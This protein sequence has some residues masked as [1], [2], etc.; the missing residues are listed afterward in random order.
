MHIRVSPAALRLASQELRDA[1]MPV[2]VTR[3]AR[4]TRVK[5]KSLWYVLKRSAP[6]L[7]KEVSLVR[8][9]RDD[10]RVT[11]QAFSSAIQRVHKRHGFA[12]YVLVG[13]ELGISARAAKDYI[14][15][16]KRLRARRTFYGSWE[17]RYRVVCASIPEPERTSSRIASAM[18]SRFH[19]GSASRVRAY[20][21]RNP[22]LAIV[23]KV[24]D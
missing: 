3:L 18:Q 23:L 6:W 14:A 19:K 5:P 20:F 2:T 9:R 17:A 10:D 1:N 4:K 16:H 12:A 13:E 21:R 8:G 15:K 22:H 24:R 7:A 11:Y